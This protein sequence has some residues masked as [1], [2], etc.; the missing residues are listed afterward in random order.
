MNHKVS[1]FSFLGDKDLASYHL[2]TVKFVVFYLTSLGGR[3]LQKN[4]HG[5]E[6][7][8]N[9]LQF[10]IMNYTFCSLEMERDSEDEEGGS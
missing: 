7:P 5:C 4:F 9:E 1:L 3:S 8:T 2:N 10:I 6:S